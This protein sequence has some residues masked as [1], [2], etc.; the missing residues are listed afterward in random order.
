MPKKQKSETPTKK[1]VL[2]PGTVKKTKPVKKAAAIKK[3]KKT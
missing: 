2:T 3:T 1:K